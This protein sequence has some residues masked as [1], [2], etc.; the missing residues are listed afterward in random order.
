MGMPLAG[1]YGRCDGSRR[2]AGRRHGDLEDE[3]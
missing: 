3:R 1:G 2:P